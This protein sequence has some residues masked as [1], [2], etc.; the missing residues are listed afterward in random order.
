[1]I[2]NV[3]WAIAMELALSRITIQINAPEPAKGAMRRRSITFTP[4][5][6]RR[7]SNSV[8]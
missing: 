6:I 4:G 7:L 3:D 8:N 1:M 5:S 2:V